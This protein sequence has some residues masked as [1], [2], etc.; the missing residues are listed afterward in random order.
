MVSWQAAQLFVLGICVAVFGVALNGRARDVADAAV[1]RRAFENRV[2]MASLARQIA[3]HAVEF[4]A[5]RQVIERHGDRRWR[6]RGQR[7]DSVTAPIVPQASARR[8]RLATLY[9][10][11]SHDP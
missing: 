3:V 6:G 5:G 10:R 4:E 11:R 7:R 8:A 1:A 2:D 9:P